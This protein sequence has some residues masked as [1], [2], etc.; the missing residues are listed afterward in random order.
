MRALVSQR[1]ATF[2]DSGKHGSGI[3]VGLID[4][5]G[6]KRMVAVGVDSAQVFE[7]GSITKTF[8]ATVL[9]DMALRG[10]VRLDDPVAQYLP[11][12]VHV[13]S[14]NGKQITLLDLATQ[15]SGLPRLPTNLA[16]RD[17]AN[18]Y[19]D[20]SVDQLYAFLSGYQLTR[21]IGAAYEYS[22][23][24][25]GLL[26][27]ALALKAGTSYENLVS[28]RI[29]TPLGMR[30]TAITLS[31]ALRARLAPGHDGDGKVVANWDLPTLAGA[32]A[33]RSTARDMLTYLAANLDTTTGPLA[34]AMRDARTPRR[35][36]G[37]PSM[38]IGLA[39]HILS[40]P[41]GNIVWH[42]GGTGGYRSYVGFDP[43]RRV[44]VVVLANVGN[45]NVDDIGFHFLDETLP[46]QAPP[47]RRTEIALDSLVLARYVGEYEFA[48]TFHI[49]V[50]REGAHL[51]VQATA[52]PRFPV[53]AE[54]DSTFFLKVVDAQIT[55]RP[56]GMVLHQNGQHL[57][58]RKV[59]SNR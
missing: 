16:P 18:P 59:A 41:A 56:D 17:S 40:R 46:L 6:A 23:L 55:F 49:T 21:D 12:T 35:D 1:V 33:L 19:A 37:R 38:Q 4:A 39:W 3:V 28:R 57:P 29:L 58:G 26:G 7:I 9:A 43:V 53:Y 52:Q 24:G 11:A 13:P 44:G 10:E 8:T 30:E 2:A 36:A 50:T 14:R 48:P 5:S 42:N 15:S 25:M 51:F 20:Y 32:G 34:G 54:S 45:A 27:H 22:N 31:P 47:P